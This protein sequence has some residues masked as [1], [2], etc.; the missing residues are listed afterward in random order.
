MRR[1]KT[2][3]KPRD[4]LFLAF[5]HAALEDRG[6][7]LPISLE[8][9]EDAFGDHE[10]EAA[11]RQ[12]FKLDTLGFQDLLDLFHRGSSDA[13]RPLLHLVNGSLRQRHAGP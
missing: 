10:L 12:V 3:D 7:S 1:P 8:R 6:A 5:R 13:V 2:L 9:R 11:T 4:D